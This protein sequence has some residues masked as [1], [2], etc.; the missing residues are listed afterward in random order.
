MADTS[1]SPDEQRLLEAFVERL[2]AEL[3]P[4]LRAV[5]LYGSRARGEPPRHEDSD[6]DLL[7]LADDASFDTEGRVYQVLDAVARELGLTDVQWT[8]S[9]H[10]EDPAWLRHRRDI[11]CFFIGEVDHDK[12][13]YYEDIDEPALR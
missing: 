7:V 9:L 3:G 2:Q 11:R 5:W 1:L 4:G 10:L 12:V 6:V 8:F 13:A